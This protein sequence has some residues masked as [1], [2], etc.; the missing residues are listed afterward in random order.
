MHPAST[1][2]DPTLFARSWLLP[3][4]SPRATA[5]LVVGTVLAMLAPTPSAGQQSPGSAAIHRAGAARVQVEVDAATMQAVANL[6]RDVVFFTS[7]S[8]PVHNLHDITDRGAQV[9][10]WGMELFGKVNR[11][12]D[13][14][15][16]EPSASGQD[17]SMLVG[18]ALFGTLFRDSPELRLFVTHAYAD[19]REQTI[20]EK[21]GGLRLAFRSR[22]KPTATSATPDA[23]ADSDVLSVAYSGTTRCS[24]MFVTVSFVVDSRRQVSHFKADHGCNGEQ[25]SLSWGAVSAVPL[26]GDGR[27][28]AEDG[29]GG[30]VWGVVNATSAS[31]RLANVMKLQCKTDGRFRDPCQDWSA[32]PTGDAAAVL[33]AVSDGRTLAESAGSQPPVTSASRNPGSPAP[34]PPYTL[35]PDYSNWTEGNE[36]ADTRERLAYRMRPRLT[37]HLVLTHSRLHP[38]VLSATG[39]MLALGYRQ[40]VSAFAGAYVRLG[41]GMANVQAD[42]VTDARGHEASDSSASVLYEGTA[43]L[44]PYAGPLGRFYLGPILWLSYRSF[45][46]DHFGFAGRSYVMPHGWLGGAGVDLGLLALAREQLETSLRVKTAF[47]GDIPLRVEIAVGWHFFP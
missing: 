36:S 15:G 9:G 21:G 27:F 47:D 12:L 22:D 4:V 32:A 37:A 10:V 43:E 23:A 17:A 41:A 20:V 19:G 24:G 46:P 38:D 6:G 28:R 40:N 42:R 34:L 8:K 16:V 29:T 3:S 33:A 7:R 2:T 30:S 44:V 11:L 5:L 26:D 25:P 39:G 1:S 35:P 31:G 45:A 13:V 18:D 14:A